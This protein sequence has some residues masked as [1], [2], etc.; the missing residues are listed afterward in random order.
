MIRAADADEYIGGL[1]I[2]NDMSARRLATG[3]NVAA[4][5]DLPKGKDFYNHYWVHGW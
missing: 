2:M 4:T 3:R 5:W 1:M